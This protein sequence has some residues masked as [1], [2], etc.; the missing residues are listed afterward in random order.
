MSGL[1]HDAGWYL[2]DKIVKGIKVPEDKRF[3]E[4]SIF[5]EGFN[6]EEE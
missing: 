6:Q 5:I 4:Y 2:A 1:A 3:Y